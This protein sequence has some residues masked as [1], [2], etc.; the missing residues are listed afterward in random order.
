MHTN[1]QCQIQMCILIRDPDFDFF[2]IDS[3]III[4]FNVLPKNLKV[5]LCII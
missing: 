2:L 4:K 3:P 5:K 1:N